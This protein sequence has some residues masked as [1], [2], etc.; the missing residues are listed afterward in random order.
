MLLF[1]QLLNIL[2]CK[3]HKHKN[4]YN[5]I[6]RNKS[7]KAH[8]AIEKFNTNKYNTLNQKNFLIKNQYSNNNTKDSLLSESK[9]IFQT[10][11]LKNNNHYS[12]INK[13]NQIQSEE[14]QILKNIE[15]LLKENNNKLETILNINNKKN[16]SNLNS[17]KNI[18]NNVK[19]I[20]DITTNNI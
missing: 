9:D 4:Y 2:N 11:I 10:E 16:Q 7:N 20:E 12:I 18:N 3:D 8:L 19:L 15:A 14:L 6:K 5:L 1:F 13:F 17:T